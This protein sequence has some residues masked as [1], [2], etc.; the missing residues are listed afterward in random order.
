[1]RFVSHPA[2]QGGCASAGGARCAERSCRNVLPIL[3]AHMCCCLRAVHIVVY[4]YNQDHACVRIVRAPCTVHVCVCAHKHTT[5]T[6]TQ[7]LPRPRLACGGINK[8]N[9]LNLASLLHSS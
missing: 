9:T 6:H 3:A 5:R 2:A 7:P 4:R 8:C 1:M